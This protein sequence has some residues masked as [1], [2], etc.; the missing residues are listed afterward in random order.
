MVQI[1]GQLYGL[2]MMGTAET[3]EADTKYIRVIQSGTVSWA[4]IGKCGDG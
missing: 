4:V 1:D 2:V 3:E